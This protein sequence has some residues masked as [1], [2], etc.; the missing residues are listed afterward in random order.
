MKR[1]CCALSAVLLPVALLAASDTPAADEEKEKVSLEG[2]F[3]TAVGGAFVNGDH[4]AFEE[5][6]QLPS[7]TLSG[8]IEELRYRRETSESSL[9][10]DGHFLAGEGDYGLNARWSKNERIF[11][12]AGYSQFRVFYDGS[13]RYYP[14]SDTFISL[15]DERLHVDRGRLWFEVGFAPEDFPHFRVRYERLTRKGEK[16]STELGETNLTGGVGSRS[17]VPS[18]IELDEVRDIVTVDAGHETKDFA[19]NTGLR[20]ERSRLDNTRQNRRRPNEPQSRAITSKDGLQSDLFTAHGY[21]ERRFSDQLRVSAGGLATTLDTNLDGSRIYGANYNST[22][23]PLFA[24]RQIADLGFLDLAGGSQLKQYVANLNA[25]YQPAKAWTLHPSIR[26]EHLH[27]DNLANFV[28][29]NVVANAPTTLQD[30]AAQTQK[31]EN[32][33][34]EVMEVRYTGRPA[35]VYTLKAEWM[36]SWGDL[37]EL[38]SDRT[39]TLSLIDRATEYTRTS[40]KYSVGAVWYARPGLSL[41]SEYFYRLRLNDYDSPRDSTR[42]GTP[43]RYPAFITNQDFSTHDFNLRLSWRPITVVS[44]VTRYDLQYSE[45]RNG[46][47]ALPQIQGAE[48][49]S[50]IVSQSVTWTPTS[51]LYLIGA[52]NLT[53]D[54]LTTPAAAYVRNS[55]NNYFNASLAAGYAVG[56]STD[57]YLDLT[58]YRANDFSDTSTLTLPYGSDQRTQTASLTTIY[59]RTANTVYTLKYTYATN[60]DRAAGGHNDF[61]A[62]VLYTKVQYKF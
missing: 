10:I 42:A 33:V 52:G 34:V 43:D 27:L 26:Y 58:H 35:W 53:Y 61:H 6:F 62:H 23:D 14:G 31:Q 8:G 2:T 57:L 32:K 29:T 16:P 17:I 36:Q 18:F 5:H 4:P 3:S 28:A 19:W 20:Y 44:L 47:T 7:K 56:K 39:T 24:Q 59:R 30:S 46:F 48:A 49:T 25:V 60:R 15:Y 41:S 22:F 38:L 54:Q 40:Q 37:T 45:V 13:G 21:A 50:H 9:A 1:L 55:D 11:I 12:N 51:R